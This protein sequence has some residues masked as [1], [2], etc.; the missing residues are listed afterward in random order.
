ME[1]EARVEFDFFE[2]DP[3]R[4]DRDWARQ[5]QLVYD[6]CRMLADAREAR[7]RAKAAEDVAKDDLKAVVARIDQEIRREPGRFGLEKITEGAVEKAVLLTRSYGE[8]L[9]LLRKARQRVIKKDHRVGILE[10]VVKA[11][12]NKKTGLE[13]CAFLWSRS[14]FADP[15][16]DQET[17]QKMRE[18]LVDSVPERRKGAPRGG[19]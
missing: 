5:A 17:H 3:T 14:Y 18:H 6:H 1:P 4:L 19:G 10:A 13:S 7:D 16:A 2:V 11:L 12:D 8:A 15:K 9:E